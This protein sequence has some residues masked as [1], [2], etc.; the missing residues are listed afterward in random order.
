MSPGNRQDHKE[1]E[2]EAL[3]G[4]V[5][6]L[7]SMDHRVYSLALLTTCDY[8]DALFVVSRLFKHTGPEL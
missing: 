7:V 5:L 8:Q 2:T 3:S 4:I 6:P 1:M